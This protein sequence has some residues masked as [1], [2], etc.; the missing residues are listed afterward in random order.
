MKRLIAA[1]GLLLG[2]GFGLVT[3]SHAGTPQ[4]QG[5]VPYQVGPLSSTSIIA[6]SAST[7]GGSFTLT[8]ATPSVYNS[9]GGSYSGR[10]CITKFVIQISSSS[11]V[12]IKDNNTTDWTLYGVD[13]G[14]SQGQTLQLADDHLGPFCIA[15]G[16]QLQVAASGGSVGAESINVEGY[17]TYGGTNNQGGPMY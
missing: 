17:T 1:F 8:V 4:E 10:I 15:S 14:V 3:Y 5:Q 9:G 13:L 12:V 2:V 16:D 6:S 11:T 7:V